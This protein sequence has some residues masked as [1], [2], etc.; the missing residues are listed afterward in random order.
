MIEEEEKELINN[1]FDFDESVAKDIMIPRIE[2]TFASVDSTYEEIADGGVLAFTMGDNLSTPWGRGN[3]NLPQT[4]IHSSESIVPV[5]VFST[6]KLTIDS[7]TLVSLSIPKVSNESRINTAE[8]KEKE[9][10]E[11]QKMSSDGKRS[12]DPWKNSDDSKKG[13]NDAQQKPSEARKGPVDQKKGSLALQEKAIS[14]VHAEPGGKYVIYYTTDGRDP[15]PKTGTRYTEPIVVD[16]EMTIKAIAVDEKEKTSKVAE[17][18]YSMYKRD[19][20]ITYITKPDPQYY[21]G[22]D[23]GLIDNLRGK[24]NYSVGGWQ[25]FLSDCE[26]I[27]DLRE[28]KSITTVGAGVLENI[29]AWIFFPKSMEVSV[30]TDGKTYKSFGT[31]TARSEKNEEARVLDLEVQGKAKARYVK[32]KI[33]NYGLLPEWHIS[34]GDQSWLFVDEVWVK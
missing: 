12:V 34:A 26:V 21:S 2:M 19:K 5:P 8:T 27:I 24:T 15:S 32:I 4:R 30:S 6:D 20:D 13:V 3:S 9:M 11:K 22:G 18:H 14:R 29:G 1:V 25:G 10:L 31:A 28:N 33:N 23:V 16:K 17:A 7:R